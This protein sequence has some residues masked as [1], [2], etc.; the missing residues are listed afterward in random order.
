M[1]KIKPGNTQKDKIKQIKGFK[2]AGAL[3]TDEE[4]EH[5]EPYKGYGRILDANELNLAVKSKLTNMI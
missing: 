2:L 1:I 5:D 3:T 4:T